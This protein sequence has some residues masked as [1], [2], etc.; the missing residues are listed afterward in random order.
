M[1]LKAIRGRGVTDREGT[2]GRHPLCSILILSLSTLRSPL[3]VFA[4]CSLRRWDLSDR[5]WTTK[6]QLLCSFAFF[7]SV[8]ALYS[9][10]FPLSSLAFSVLFKGESDTFPR[11]FEKILEPRALTLP[12]Y[13][14]RAS[15][16]PGSSSS[17]AWSPSP[18]CPFVSGFGVLLPGVAVSTI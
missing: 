18:S 10:L 1:K 14:L 6:G 4:F 13:I 5:E 15:T 17:M 16:A 8:S 3:P 11:L 7:S 2:T 12:M 9:L